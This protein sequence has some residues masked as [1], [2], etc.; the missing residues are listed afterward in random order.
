MCKALRMIL[1]STE[2]SS[3]GQGKLRYQQGCVQRR[4]CRG[5][6]SP[7][8]SQPGE[9]AYILGLVASFSLFR[10]VACGSLISTPH[11]GKKV[12]LVLPRYWSMLKLKTASPLKKI[13]SFLTHTP[14][15]WHTIQQLPSIRP[16]PSEISPPSNSATSWQLRLIYILAFLM[17][18]RSKQQ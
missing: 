7:C 17:P 9:V 14:S 10:S 1:S 15:I 6:L 11:K 2:C 12:Q 13:E 3:G 8:L 18:L 16:Y 5:P 4:G